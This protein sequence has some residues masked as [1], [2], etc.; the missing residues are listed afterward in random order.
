MSQLPELKPP[1]HIDWD[2]IYREGTPHWETGVPAAEFGSRAGGGPGA[3]RH[4]P[5]I[6]L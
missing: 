6:G 5:G 1:R 4:G 3:A 2:A